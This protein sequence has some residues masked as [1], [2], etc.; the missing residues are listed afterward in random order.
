VQRFSSLTSVGLAAEILKAMD[1]SFV[2]KKL[3]ELISQNLK[4]AKEATIETSPLT[5]HPIPNWYTMQ[6]PNSVSGV[7]K[8]QL[9]SFYTPQN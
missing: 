5:E 4:E 8:T 3:T 2:A 6:I 9:Y 1:E 7:T